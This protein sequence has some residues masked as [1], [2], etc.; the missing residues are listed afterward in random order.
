MDE[1]NEQEKHIALKFITEA[2]SWIESKKDEFVENMKADL[3]KKIRDHLKQRNIELDSI[4]VA[5]IVL[6]LGDN[7][8]KVVT[9]LFETKKKLEAANIDNI[10]LLAA[11]YDLDTKYLF[12]ENKDIED[13]TFPRRLDKVTKIIEIEDTGE[14]G[15]TTTQEVGFNLNWDQINS[16]DWV[17]FIEA[18]N[19]NYTGNQKSPA[20]VA[21]LALF[22]KICYT[23]V[24]IRNAAG[25]S[26]FDSLEYGLS[27]PFYEDQLKSIEMTS[28]YGMRNSGMH[29]GVDLYA[30][31]GEEIH[32]SGDGTVVA[33]WPAS[34]G[35]A[36]GNRICI[37]HNENVA[38]WYMHMNDLLLSNGAAVTKGQVIGHVGC[39]GRCI[40]SDFTHLH[41]QVNENGNNNSSGA[42]DPAKYFTR[43]ASAPLSTPLSQVN[44]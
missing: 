9:K 12:G 23:Y 38:T 5:S 1:T 20:L 37:Q 6:A 35:N 15:G 10:V 18:L 34:D 44:D 36:G 40:P 11:F 22:A 19:I 3:A 30:P 33:S 32:A 25:S 4:L 27:F 8:E 28:P 24:A 29:Y 21:K 41:F 42:V 17:N 39:T 31:L 13:K 7:A 14:G 26:S 16:W 2:Q 43:L